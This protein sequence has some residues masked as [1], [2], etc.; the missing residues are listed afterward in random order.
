MAASNKQLS[1]R[2]L[3]KLTIESVAGL[4]SSYMP[5]VD[6]GGLFMPGT[7]KQRIGDEVF[8]MLRLPDCQEW[9]PSLARVVWKTPEG[10]QNGLVAGIG[11]QFV[12]PDDSAS[13]KIQNM[14]SGLGS[15]QD[16][17]DSETAPS[18]TL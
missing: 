5:F 9:L 6:N 14:L 17:C 18:L 15:D 11:V 4:Q 13:E 2:S 7:A 1:S 3:F 8:V 16:H 10:A 12:N